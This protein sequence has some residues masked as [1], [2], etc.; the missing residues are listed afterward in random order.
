MYVC[1]LQVSRLQ[2]LITVGVFFTAIGVAFKKKE[3]TP[4]LLLYLI[5]WMEYLGNSD[6][7]PPSLQTV[8][9]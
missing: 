5:D 8:V 4:F 9:E 6:V 2:C 1:Y 7:S 3:K